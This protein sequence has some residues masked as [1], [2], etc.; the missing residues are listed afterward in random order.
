MAVSSLA[1]RMPEKKI[2]REK[3]FLPGKK[4][5]TSGRKSSSLL[6]STIRI[7]NT[8]GGQMM[9]CRRLKC[10]AE[11]FRKLWKNDIPFFSTCLSKIYLFIYPISATIRYV[12]WLPVAMLCVNITGVGKCFLRSSH[13]SRWLPKAN[14]LSHIRLKIKPRK[15]C[16]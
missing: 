2:A 13:D 12:R 6:Y 16:M 1:K 5:K 9:C 11:L 4:E 10:K 7:R 15:L 3:D 14:R 8:D